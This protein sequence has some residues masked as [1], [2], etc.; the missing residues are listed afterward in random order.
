VGGRRVMISLEKK[1]SPGTGLEAAYPISKI[2]EQIP[3]AGINE[4]NCRYKM[5]DRGKHRQHLEK[6]SSECLTAE[7][8]KD[9]H[10]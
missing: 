6:I 7:N 5:W 3:A 9:D 2:L 10:T 8:I 4:G 1:V